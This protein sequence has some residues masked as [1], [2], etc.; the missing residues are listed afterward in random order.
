[1]VGKSDFFP[2]EINGRQGGGTGVFRRSFIKSDR[3]IYEKMKVQDA[4]ALY[5]TLVLVAS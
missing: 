3:T 5:P 4:A 1:M 2:S